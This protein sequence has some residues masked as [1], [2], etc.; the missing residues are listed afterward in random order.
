MYQQHPKLSK[1]IFSKVINQSKYA[2]RLNI[3]YI[4]IRKYVIFEGLFH[5]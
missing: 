5:I 3:N 1:G 4:F 2:M